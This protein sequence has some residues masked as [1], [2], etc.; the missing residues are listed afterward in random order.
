[1]VALRSQ[2]DYTRQ[3]PGLIHLLIEQFRRARINRERA[4]LI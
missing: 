1:V 2:Y 4:E 3:P